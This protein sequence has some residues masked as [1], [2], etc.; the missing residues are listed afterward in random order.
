M[1]TIASLDPDDD[2]QYDDEAYMPPVVEPPNAATQALLDLLRERGIPTAIDFDGNRC[3]PCLHHDRL[4]LARGE[5]GRTRLRI[6]QRPDD[7]VWIHPPTCGCTARQVLTALGCRDWR[8][9]PAGTTP[10]PPQ[11]PP[12]DSPPHRLLNAIIRNLQYGGSR[13]E[14]IPELARLVSVC[15]VDR[16]GGELQAY[17]KPA[18]GSIGERLITLCS[19]GHDA[20]EVHRA[21]GMTTPEVLESDYGAANWALD[22]RDDGDDDGPDWAIEPLIERG[23]FGSIYGPREVGKSLLALDYACR[24][25]GQAAAGTIDLYSVL[26]LDHENPRDEI[27]K[28]IRAMGHTAADLTRLVY[29][30]FPPIRALDTEAGAA[31]FVELVGRASAEFVV[32]DTWS[33]FIDG[34][35][36]SPTTHTRAYNLAIVPVRRE[37][38]AVLA[39]DH[40]GKDVNRGPRGGSSKGDN[41]DVEWLLTAKS[42]GRLRLER[43]KSRTGRGPDLVELVR[44]T[45]PLRHERIDLAPADTLGAEVR[46][47]VA[48][49]DALDVPAGWGRERVAEA[50]RANAYRVRTATLAAAL[51]VRRERGGASADSLDLFPEQ[52]EQREQPV[53]ESGTGREQVQP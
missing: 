2:Y 14:H 26:Y 19:K 53:P 4:S 37:G 23:Q 47:C 50:L 38:V 17:V 25:A 1:D 30:H 43:R 49:L 45:G 8:I 6:E 29:A 41:V 51:R 44:R 12:P 20:H 5:P 24:L 10:E 48:K 18:N 33:K 52:R 27:L 42:G 31:S 35:E 13:V 32:L 7:T 9:V 22:L 46:E 21:L 28:R 3:M 16:C 39:L 36:A 15:P 34:D 40:A 11:S